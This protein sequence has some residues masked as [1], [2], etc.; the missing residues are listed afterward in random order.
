MFVLSTLLSKPRFEHPEA[1]GAM[2]WSTSA[3]HRWARKNPIPTIAWMAAQYNRAKDALGL[4]NGWGSIIDPSKG[5]SLYYLERYYMLRQQRIDGSLNLVMDLGTPTKASPQAIS[6]KLWGQNL[7]KLLFPDKVMPGFILPG[8]TTYKKIEAPLRQNGKIGFKNFVF[9]CNYGQ[10]SEA[11][12]EIEASWPPNL[13]DDILAAIERL[14]GKTGKVFGKDLFVSVRGA[15]AYFSPGA[16]DTILNVGITEKH[17]AAAVKHGNPDEIKWAYDSYRRL[18]TM[19]AISVFQL[20]YQEFNGI[21][22][23]IKKENGIPDE[24]PLT[25]VKDLSTALVKT[26]E[27]F[28]KR[29]GINFCDAP[30]PL[31]VLSI[32]AAFR[33]HFNP[34]AV[35]FR[36]EHGLPENIGPSVG[37]QQMAFGNLGNSLTGVAFSRN[38]SNGKPE[39]IVEWLQGAQG[40]D[41]V[42]GIRKVLSWQELLERF[43]FFAEELDSTLGKFEK[44]FGRMQE[45]EFTGIDR[46]KDLE[47]ELKILQRRTDKDLGAAAVQIAV[48]MVN[49]GIIT[50]EQA[51]LSVRQE[52]VSALLFPYIP[53]EA[54][55]AAKEQGLFLGK[56]L[57]GAPGAFTGRVVMFREKAIEWANENPASRQILVREVT[58]PSDNDGILIPQTVGLATAKG[59]MTAHASVVARGAGKG[60]VPM[61]ENLEVNE[62]E[63]S[64]TLGGK[65][66]KE[67]DIITIDGHRGEVFLGEVKTVPVKDLPE[68]L[69][70]LLKWADEVR[71][72]KI[73]AN[74]DTLADT[75]TAVKYGA[76]G[77]GLLRTEHTM[78]SA[79]LWPVV[80]N[81]IL[82]ENAEARKE[83]LATLKEAHKKNFVAVYTAMA[84]RSQV[85]Q[86]T[87]R[88]LDPPLHEFLPDILKITE[89][90]NLR[91]QGIAP[92]TTKENVAL[93]EMPIAELELLLE[94]V[95][96]MHEHNPMLGL[97]GVRLGIL[98]QDI[99][100]MQI[101]A[102][103][104]AAVE[105]RKKGLYIVPEI[106]VPLVSTPKELDPILKIMEEVRGKMLV[107][108]KIP[109]TWLEYNVGTMI[110]LPGAAVNAEALVKTLKYHL[111]GSLRKGVKKVFHS[112]GTNDLTQTTLGL[113]RDDAAKIIDSYLRNRIYE[114]DPFVTIHP[115]V[116]QMV[117]ISVGRAKA[118]DENVEIGVCGE[119][120]GDTDSISFFHAV[121]VDYVSASPYRIPIARLAAA[122]A[123]LI[124]E[125]YHL[126][127]RM[128]GK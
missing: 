3:I 123:R 109:P 18:I 9:A 45:V 73:R 122:Q 25:E 111:D 98:M 7:V 76:E 54:R 74:A 100:R 52:D 103:F 4:E 108:Q 110:E 50:K 67:G 85:P 121:G 70:T 48:D 22:S 55:R 57:A 49:E 105:M 26:Q 6:D 78:F 61:I 86:V 80:Q 14:E 46:G 64:F 90:L 68:Q 77:N 39:R 38:A 32:N 58:S 75:Q 127:D 96:K 120:G 8:S 36:K 104:E 125:G 69:V 17:I 47:P 53:E 37:I 41:V 117:R 91:R 43:P 20:D 33:S 34:E 51:L 112:F 19:T 2:A 23:K 97:R 101:E 66:V 30:W 21:I 95:K 83:P 84:K 13:K 16:M 12:E 24:A 92:A 107:E 59:G 114:K 28:K 42:A 65:T 93:W 106:E 63:R 15:P 29:T 128:A 94:K 10:L 1:I 11:V 71:T 119:H 62:Q 113:S 35:A 31:L 116:Q 5:R 44:I 27:L 126:K 79:E 87:V 99:Y 124:E 88:L 89:I 82:G 56:G 81:L 118:A 115:A 102:V 60:C 72:L 40:E